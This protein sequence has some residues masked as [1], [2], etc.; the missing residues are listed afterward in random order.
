MLGQTQIKQNIGLRLKE[1]REKAGFATP[2][3]FCKQ[4]NIAEDTYLE[5]ES[6]ERALKATTAME[7][8]KLLNVSMQWLLL[9]EELENK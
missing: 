2:G 6:G 1:A 8:S 9:G 5:Y 4:F 3:D 7:Y